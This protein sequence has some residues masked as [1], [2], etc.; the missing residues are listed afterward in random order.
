MMKQF[1]FLCSLL[2]VAIVSS[3]A[4]NASEDEYYYDDYGIIAGSISDKT[5]GEPVATVNVTLDPSGASTVTG[6]DGTF[7]FHNLY[8]YSYTLSISKE[9]Y[10]PNSAEV[11]VP[12]GETTPVHLLIERIPAIVTADRDLLDFGSNAST[13]T[14]S[15]NIVNSS[16]EDLEWEIEERCDWITE[17]KPQKGTLRYGKTEAIVVVIDRA[18]LSDGENEAVL[19]VRSS[20]GSTEVRVAA[21]GDAHAFPSVTI[22][23]PT[24][25]STSSAILSGEITDEGAPAYTERGFVYATSSMP[26]LEN[27]MKVTAP[28]STTATYSCTIDKLTFGETYYARAYVRNANGVAYSKNETHFTPQETVAKVETLEVTDA[29]ISAGTATFRGTIVGAGD[30]S[31]TERG[32]V[33]STMHEP[34]INDNVIRANGS[35]VIGSYSAYVENLPKSSYYVRAY[36]TNK[37][38][39]A[40]GEEI[41][42]SEDWVV[43]SGLGIAVQKEDIGYNYWESINGMCVNSTLGG[44]TDWRLPTKEELMSLY[45]N[46]DYIGNFY[47]GE[48][49]YRY[50]WSSSLYESYY[51]AYYYIDFRDGYLANHQ[52]YRGSGRCVRTIKNE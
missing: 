52:L 39:T 31:Y 7:S 47:T 19:V 29:D 27:A 16:Y 6:S 38:G 28:S 21:K 35:A 10:K 26:T 9:G 33:Y 24:Y 44:Y 18:V 36:A 46:R 22:Y 40:Y 23:E 48:G 34:T 8:D 15:F 37:V 11:Y 50:Y 14:L 20:N 42:V 12:M 32:F 3:C 51:S 45:V 4:D 17:V 5:T 1:Y 49:L 25:I 41:A 43:L 2:V 13:N 30:P